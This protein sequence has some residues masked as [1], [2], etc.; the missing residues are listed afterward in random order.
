METLS[1]ILLI[2]V[3]MLVLSIVPFWIRLKKSE[4]KY[5]EHEIRMFGIDMWG[6][7]GTVIALAI[8]VVTNIFS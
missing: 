4:N 2:I 7:L 1:V 3:T 8:I 6:M 5:N